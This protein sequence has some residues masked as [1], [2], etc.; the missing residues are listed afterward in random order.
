MEDRQTHSN[1]GPGN[2]HEATPGSYIVS[3]SIRMVGWREQELLLAEGHYRCPHCRRTD[4][5]E[6]YP[7]GVPRR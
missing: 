4:M 5:M 3:Q 7:A 6:M 2:Q 1:A